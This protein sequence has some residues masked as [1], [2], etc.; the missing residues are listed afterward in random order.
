MWAKK[1]CGGGWM[2]APQ[3][4]GLFRFDD[5]HEPLCPPWMTSPC[6][7]WVRAKSELVC[8]CGLRL[9]VQWVGVCMHCTV[10]ACT[11]QWVCVCMHGTSARWEGAQG[12]QGGGGRVSGRCAGASSTVEWTRAWT[13][14]VWE[15]VKL[16]LC[17]K[18][19]NWVL[20][21]GG[22]G[23]S[24]RCEGVCEVYARVRLCGLEGRR[25]GAGGRR[26]LGEVD[27]RLMREA[28]HLVFSPLH[29]ILGARQLP[30]Q[31]FHLL[32]S[33]PQLLLT[34]SDVLRG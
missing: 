33:Q 34:A 26:N 31:V 12:V 20:R 9:C 21:G 17:G 23:A 11:V 10:C 29:L 13:G 24:K 18:R 14:S 5:D 32:P 16:G 25:R 6:A 27:S 1:A 7:H 4:V 30:P 8:A 3:R 2:T 28:L 15:A 22:G 19:S